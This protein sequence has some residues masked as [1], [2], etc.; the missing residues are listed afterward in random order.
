MELQEGKRAQEGEIRE[1]TRRVEALQAGVDGLEGENAGLRDGGARLEAEV[2][3]LRRERAELQRVEGGLRQQV[4]D[5]EEALAQARALQAAAQQGQARAEE[6]LALYKGNALQLQE[7]LEGSVSEIQRG[8]QIIQKLQGE[9]AELKRK[10]RSKG[11]VL[12]QQE[13]L[14][15]ERQRALDEAQHRLEAA[16][17]DG[18]RAEGELA[19]AT[20]KLEEAG[21]LNESNQQVITWLN[22]EI[23]DLQLGRGSGLLPAYHGGGKQGGNL[24]MASGSTAA[25]YTP[26]YARY[27]SR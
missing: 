27:A 10:V 20:A 11:E 6:A 15:Q 8:N 1:L 16:T 2:A 21:R 9:G 13:R 26:A 22:K 24:S 18:A 5:R 4:A 14:L 23:N 19:A 25:T 12:K 7:R 17:R 3:A